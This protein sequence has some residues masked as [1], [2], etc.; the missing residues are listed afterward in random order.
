M[1]NQSGYEALQS[2]QSGCKI[3][4]KRISGLPK[5]PRPTK[6]MLAYNDTIGAKSK[7]VYETRWL[8]TMSL[9]P[10]LL[11][12]QKGQLGLAH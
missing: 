10:E 1:V 2:G 8:Y 3:S 12:D 5:D 11:D 4:S 7:S 6:D 9:C